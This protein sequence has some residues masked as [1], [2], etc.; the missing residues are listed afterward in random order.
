MNKDNLVGTA[1]NYSGKVESAIGNMTGDAGLKTDGMIDQV[2]G[3]AQDLYGDARDIVETVLDNAPIVVRENAERAT[4]AAKAHPV[5][6]AMVAGTLGLALALSFKL[7][8]RISRYDR[9]LSQQ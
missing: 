9:A 4:A 7:G 6:L 2:K 8:S 1:T 3:R 5:M